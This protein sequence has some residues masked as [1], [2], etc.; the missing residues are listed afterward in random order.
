MNSYTGFQLVRI[1]MTLIDLERSNGRNGRLMSAVQHDYVVLNFV[2]SMKHAVGIK[3]THNSVGQSFHVVSK[4]FHFLVSC[5]LS[6]SD[7]S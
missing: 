3:I 5:S 4:D 7:R 2:F 6:C 1:S